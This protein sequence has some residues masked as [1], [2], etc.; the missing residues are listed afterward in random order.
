M[1]SIGWGKKKKGVQKAPLQQLTSLKRAFNRSW[2]F[3]FEGPFQMPRVLD[4]QNFSKSAS[5]N[6]WIGSFTELGY[7]KWTFEPASSVK[8]I[9]NLVS[10]L[11][12]NTFEYIKK[13]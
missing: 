3:N 7:S 10:L 13:K 12:S 2:T 1:K 6:F 8:L 4:L 5:I 9:G 11:N